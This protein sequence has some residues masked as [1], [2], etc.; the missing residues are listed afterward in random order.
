MPVPKRARLCQCGKDAFCLAP[1]ESYRPAAHYLRTPKTAVQE[2]EY[3]VDQVVIADVSV[4]FCHLAN[5]STLWSLSLSC[6]TLEQFI[7]L[8]VRN[9]PCQMARCTWLADVA[10][11]HPDHIITSHNPSSRLVALAPRN[12]ERELDLAACSQ[13]QYSDCGQRA[14]RGPAT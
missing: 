1:G 10:L 12:S 9:I 3:V 14:L 13:L 11:P 2:G 5:A 4:L 7:G 6:E 8:L